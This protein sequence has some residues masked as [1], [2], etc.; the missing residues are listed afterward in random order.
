MK[1]HPTAS[2]VLA[3]ALA[4]S[5]PWRLIPV[6]YSAEPAAAPDPDRAVVTLS[7]GETAEGTL[8]FPSNR[9]PSFFDVQK[10][11]RFDLDPAEIVRIAVTVEEESLA[12]G[13]MFIEESRHDKVK[14]PYKYP[15]RKLTTEVTLTSGETLKGHVTSV[16]YLETDDTQRRFFLLADQ[17]GEKDQALE[18]LLYVKAVVLPNRKAGGKSAGTIRAPA[19]PGAVVNVDRE[20]S[21]QPPFTNLPTG[22]YDVFLFKGTAVRY[23]LAGAP[24]SAADRAKLDAKVASVEE[25]YTGKRIVAAAREGDTVRALVELTRKE[26]GY[27]KEWRYARW[28]VWTF[29]PTQE[30]WAIRKR[31]Y[32]HRERFPAE[33]GVPAFE[34]RAEETLKGV[35]ENARIE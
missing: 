29:E 28:E 26:E 33:K 32:L 13:W 15:L 17:K 1:G 11:K 12:Q 10:S 8:V 4:L 20:V 2:Q 16:F 34:Y 7:N 30:S 35:H 23:G 31:L 22:R 18:A 25:F 3:L 14:L 27:E 24:P 21:F 6:S 9:K 19:G 5:A